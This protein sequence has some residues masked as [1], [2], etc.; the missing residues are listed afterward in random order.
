MHSVQGAPNDKG[1]LLARDLFKTL[2]ERFLFSTIH[3][4]RSKVSAMVQL[5]M[6]GKSPTDSQQW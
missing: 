2:A 6:M 1:I 3:F 4:Q 5:K